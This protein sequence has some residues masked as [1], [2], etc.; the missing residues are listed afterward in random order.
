MRF[1]LRLLPLLAIAVGCTPQGLTGPN[2]SYQVPPNGLAPGKTSGPVAP[3]VAPSPKPHRPP[4]TVQG[5]LP[6]YPYPTPSAPDVEAN[7]VAGIVLSQGQPAASISVNVIGA[8]NGKTYHLATDANGVYRVKSLPAG[9]YY[10]HYYNDSDNNKVGYW[11]TQN[12]EVSD[13]RGGV[14]PAWDVYLVGMKNTPGQGQSVSFPFTAEFKPYP[15]AI[16]YRFRIHDAGGPGGHPLY[17]SEK[18]PAKGV[19]RFTFTGENNQGG[20]NLGPGRYLWGYQW[21]S[22]AAGVGGCLF[23]DFVAMNGGSPESAAA[24]SS[25]GFANFPSTGY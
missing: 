20:S 9:R 15:L 8:N 5:D 7:E 12:V 25:P 4:F 2:N 3:D 10:A 21:E 13:E 14:W 18:T 17:I 22:G 1:A 24:S 6:P 16:N 11:Q 19:E 23:Q